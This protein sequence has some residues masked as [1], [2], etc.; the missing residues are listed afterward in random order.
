MKNKA[1]EINHCRFFFSPVT[2]SEHQTN[3]KTQITK[4]VCAGGSQRTTAA[5]RSR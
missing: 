3:A 5:C 1:N 2:L 4:L